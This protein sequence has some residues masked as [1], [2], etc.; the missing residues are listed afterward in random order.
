MPVRPALNSQLH[1]HVTLRLR[2]VDSKPEQ[3]AE[4]ST[5]KSR[6]R[7]RLIR[8]L[9]WFDG[10]AAQEEGELSFPEGLASPKALQAPG[11]LEALLVP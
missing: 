5:S 10:G 8:F 7:I 4:P 9:V 2:G 11:Q 1:K 6:K 3:A